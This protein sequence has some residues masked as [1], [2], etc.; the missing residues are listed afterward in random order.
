MGS[1]SSGMPRLR[2]RASQMTLFNGL[3]ENENSDEVEVEGTRGTSSSAPPVYSAP[4]SKSRIRKK[5][6]K[7]SPTPASNMLS[8]SLNSLSTA[9]TFQEH[10]HKSPSPVDSLNMQDYSDAQ[11]S[12]LSEYS[13]TVIPPDN[14]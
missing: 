7:P 12:V 8:D 9:A 5:T 10:H 13:N 2:S 1:T 14:H 6:T 11:L 4:V 3:G